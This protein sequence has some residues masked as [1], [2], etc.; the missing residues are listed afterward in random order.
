MYKFILSLGTSTND[1]IMSW[2]YLSAVGYGTYY[3]T[4]NLW[5]VVGA[6]FITV[7][8]NTIK[9]VSAYKKGVDTGSQITKE[10]Y[11][12]AINRKIEE[13]TEQQRRKTDETD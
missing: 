3:A 6:C 13:M 10:L 12:I 2:I 9:W 4:N 8:Y 7:I 5:A 1:N 11:E